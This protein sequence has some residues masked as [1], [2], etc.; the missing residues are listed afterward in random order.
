[1]AVWRALRFPRSR[2]HTALPEGMNPKRENARAAA[3]GFA[4]GKGSTLS[5]MIPVLSAAERS[6]KVQICSL[7]SETSVCE[8]DWPDLS[9][10]FVEA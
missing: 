5:Q 2:S 6:A 4:V 10:A 9:Q 8:P 7:G 3:K 1:V